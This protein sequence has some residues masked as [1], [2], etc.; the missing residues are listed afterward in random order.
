MIKDPTKVM[1]FLFAMVISFFTF[2]IQSIFVAFISLIVFIGCG[3][4]IYK[5]YR[6][7]T[8]EEE[9]EEDNEYLEV[10]NIIDKE[11]FI[12]RIFRDEREF[13]T[14]LSAYLKAKFPQY[15]I[16]SQYRTPVG[17]KIDIVV[18][19]KY[20][21]ELKVANSRADLDDVFSKIHWYRKHF[22][23]LIIVILDVGRFEDTNYYAQEFKS[24]GV[25][26]I[27]KM[28]RMSLHNDSY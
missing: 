15:K 25:D 7:D 10:L 24:I 19:N 9:S 13:E 14:D 20:A 5:L 23:K 12:D 18:D 17:D 22:D 3:Y 8:S 21:I 28:G 1:W 27:V 16:K 6:K 2:F 4:N 26:A 11:Y